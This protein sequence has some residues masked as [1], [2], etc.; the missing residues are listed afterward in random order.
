MDKSKRDIYF[1]NLLGI[2]WRRFQILTLMNDPRAQFDCKYLDFSL[3]YRR[4]TCFWRTQLLKLLGRI[5]SE[6]GDSFKLLDSIDVSS[7]MYWKR[8]QK[9]NYVCLQD[10]EISE[11]GHTI[12]LVSAWYFENLRLHRQLEIFINLQQKLLSNLTK[13]CNVS[14][15]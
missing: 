10:D 12:K 3:L 11:L 13:R 15:E 7:E 4:Y 1:H 2:K 14:L 5:S 6:L 9:F 8:L